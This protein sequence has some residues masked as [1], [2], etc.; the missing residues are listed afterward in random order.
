MH[1]AAF[2]PQDAGQRVTWATCDQ[3]TILQTELSLDETEQGVKFDEENNEV[4]GEVW[5]ANGVLLHATRTRDAHEDDSIKATAAPV[6]WE[7]ADAVMHD[8]RF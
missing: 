5:R 3:P 7:L 4:T 6:L 2:V 1:D 8:A